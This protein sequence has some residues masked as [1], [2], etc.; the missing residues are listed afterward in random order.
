MKGFRSILIVDDSAT[1]RM[2]IQRCVE[3]CGVET[4]EF[5]QAENG[6]DA[7]T[8]LDGSDTVDLI[9]SDINMP[10]MDGTTFIKLVKNKAATM[11]IPIVVTSS[12]ASSAV[13]PGMKQLGVTGIIQKPVSPEKVLAIL[14]GIA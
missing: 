4:G 9:F 1:S 11:N 10:K 2:I 3:M 12:I 6:I 8:A 13:E 7:L 14:G 5:I